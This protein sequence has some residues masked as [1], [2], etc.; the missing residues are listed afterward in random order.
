MSHSLAVFA[1]SGDA[2]L[3]IL[4]SSMHQLWAI[5]H[6]STLET[7]VRYTPVQ[8]FGTF[9]RP[10]TTDR[11]ESV[12]LRLEE[13][14]REVMLRRQL[15]MTKLYNII[16]DPDIGIGDDSD[17]HCLREIH[18]EIDEAVMEAYGWQDL[19]LDHGFS[20]HRQVGRFSVSPSAGEEI[21]ERLLLENRRRAEALS[22]K[23]NSAGGLDV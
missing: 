21:L 9:P 11:L 16:N 13:A 6:G 18:T 22:D 2:D 8:C 10:A 12:G 15:G 5:T 23:S 17:V 19:K 3:A 7:R 14:R 4:S 20:V 1:L